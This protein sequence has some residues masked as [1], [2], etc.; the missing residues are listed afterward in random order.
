MRNTL[1]AAVALVV[2][3]APA[4]MALVPLYSD[5]YPVSGIWSVTATPNNPGAN[6]WRWDLTLIGGTGY[7]GG[8]VFSAVGFAV[9]DDD[10]AT[11][12]FSEFDWYTNP[13]TNGASVEWLQVGGDPS[14]PLGESTYFTATIDQLDDPTKVSLMIWEQV[15]D[16]ESHGYWARLAPAAETPELS[17]WLLLGLSGLAGAFM[18][19]RRKA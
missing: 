2:L 5:A 12:L 15:S 9:Y 10:P 14:L 11:N 6:D 7:F 13:L 3:S 16:I 17:T 8:T 19:R 18:A 4:A 1:I